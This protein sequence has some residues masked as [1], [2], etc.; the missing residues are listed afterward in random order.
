MKKYL[1]CWY[2]LDQGMEGIP[3]LTDSFIVEAKDAKDAIHKFP[4]KLKHEY[5]GWGHVCVLGE[6][7]NNNVLVEKEH[8]A[9][10]NLVE[11]QFK[12]AKVL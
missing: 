2:F 6:I 11:W 10:R 9:Y 1:I 3:S 12:E 8:Y 4:S 5:K 7:V